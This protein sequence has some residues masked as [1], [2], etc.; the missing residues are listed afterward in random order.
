MKC[1]SEEKVVKQCDIEVRFLNATGVVLLFFLPKINVIN[2]GPNTQEAAIDSIIRV[3]SLHDL[4]FTTYKR[5]E[6]SN[7]QNISIS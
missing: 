4:T 3:I 1:L 7:F 2:K 6:L 5:W